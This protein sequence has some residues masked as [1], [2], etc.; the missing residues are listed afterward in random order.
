MV[1]ERLSEAKL[2]FLALP[3]L[4]II[5]VSGCTTGSTVSGNGVIVKEFAPEFT[6]IYAGEPVTFRL[7]MQNQGS[8]NANN[9]HAELLGLDEDWCASQT[10]GNTCKSSA[11]NRAEM[12]PNEPECQYTGTNFNMLAPDPTRGTS[13]GSHICT[14]TYNAPPIQKGFTITYTPTVRV[15]YAYNSGV[16]KLITFG[17]SN[18]LR[19]IQDTGGKLPAETKSQT[20]SP[21]MLDIQ[22]KGPIRFWQ[23]ENG[24]IVP[25]EITINNVGG[26]IACADPNSGKIQGSCKSTVAQSGENAQNK[27]KLTI[28]FG[29]DSSSKM[30]LQGEA[31]AGFSTGKVI[32][33]WK[34]QSNSI[35]CEV[36]AAGLN[37]VST[38]QRMIQV[39]ADYEYY[40]DTSSSIKVIGR[41]TVGSSPNYGTSGSG[42]GDVS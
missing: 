37:S 4:A 36:L 29:T 5:L 16:V 11:G 33:L 42:Y 1:T 26:G 12:L 21:I 15:F 3:V 22:T 24:V 25:V 13:G 9:V 2:F 39:T 7:L 18:E 32:S 27:V 34:G 14:W 28:S 20:S 19:N 17:S 8:V 23:G 30:S 31:C 35:V 40:T 10:G 41:E 6:E 38:V